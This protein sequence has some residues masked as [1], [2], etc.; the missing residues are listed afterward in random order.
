MGRII[1]GSALPYEDFVQKQKSISAEPKKQIERS[2]MQKAHDLTKIIQDP[3]GYYTRQAF[4]K[5]KP[6]IAK[7]LKENL[8][9]GRP[10]EPET[11]ESWGEYGLRALAKAPAQAYSNVRTGLGLGHYAQTAIGAFPKEKTK[12]LRSFLKEYLPSY[13]QAEKEIAEYLPDYYYASRQGDLPAELITGQ[14]PFAAIGGVPKTAGQLL[15]QI[16]G[17]AARIGATIG[18][19]K[20][21]EEIGGLFE[22]S[23]NL[24]EEEREQIL[25]YR[26][27]LG[28][29]I[30]GLAGGAAGAIG[31]QMIVK[32]AKAVLPSKFF[33][34][35]LGKED[36]IRLRKE[37]NE[38]KAAY[39]KARVK[40]GGISVKHQ[41]QKLKDI[42]A[43]RKKLLQAKNRTKML[44]E[45]RTKNYAIATE[46]ETKYPVDASDLRKIIASHKKGSSLRGISRKDKKLINDIIR[47]IEKALLAGENDLAIGK[48]NISISELKQIKQNINDQIYDVSASTNFKKAAAP[49]I[50]GIKKIIKDSNDEAH[51]IAYERAEAET[52]QL[53]KVKKAVKERE[54]VSRQKEADIRRTKPNQQEVL[55]AKDASTEARKEM[56]K[57]ASLMPK[58][59][60]MADQHFRDMAA[61]KIGAA[62][63]QIK[64]PYTWGAF[65]GMLAYAFPQLK[66][67]G[68]LGLGGKA[69]KEYGIAQRAR[70][71][72]PKIYNSFIKDLKRIATSS[73][74]QTAQIINAWTKKMEDVVD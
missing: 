17:T 50:Q 29:D 58:D 40:E 1:S 9:V 18:G 38:K 73:V 4:E 53:F 55:A 67:L 49:Y 26:K 63:S 71:I 65:V 5:L 35:E 41:Q 48:D 27:R 36:A 51:N 72:D 56:N 61:R 3:I 8:P 24:P 15:R 11:P 68:A 43:V 31:K 44:D 19:G 60:A 62:E 70:M 34:E 47:D 2:R 33:P 46:L 28:R 16:P 69:I 32:G 23:Q 59:E 42:E 7:T 64:D 39:K 52:R 22:P 30:G 10:E 66:W 45:S 6:T 12:P 21:G 13:E 37:L 57:A 74:P 20:I 14:L 54:K 25:E